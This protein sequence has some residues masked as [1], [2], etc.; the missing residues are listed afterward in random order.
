[1]LL[2]PYACEHSPTSCHQRCCCC[3]SSEARSS[4]CCCWYSARGGNCSAPVA[5]FSPAPPAAAVGTDAIATAAVTAV[6]TGPN[7]WEATCNANKNTQC[8][9]C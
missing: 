7:G 3:D 8:R 5:P 9:C 1:L 6:A 4:S 2:H